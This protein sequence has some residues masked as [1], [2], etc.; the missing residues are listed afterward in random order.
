[1]SSITRGYR[2]PSRLGWLCWLLGHPWH[3][4]PRWL[5]R[6]AKEPASRVCRRCGLWEQEAHEG[7]WW[8]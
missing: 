5:S 1:M 6:M 3:Y 2:W 8:R 4:Q 7:D